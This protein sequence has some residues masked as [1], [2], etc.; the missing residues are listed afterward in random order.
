MSNNF[1]AQQSDSFSV[2]DHS[3]SFISTPDH[4]HDPGAIASGSSS[5]FVSVSREVSRQASPF[6]T[7]SRL[8][9]RTV[10]EPNTIET[11]AGPSRA[12]QEIEQDDFG[13]WADSEVDDAD[14]PSDLKPQLNRAGSHLLHQ[15]L[16]AGDKPQRYASP[17]RSRN[18]S[19]TRQSSRFR[20]RESQTAT[21]D[22]TRTR[23]TYAA[24]FLVISLIT[25]AIQTETAVYIQHTLKWNKAYCM[26]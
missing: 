12:I 1:R 17:S 21:R 11:R 2:P 25:F 19:R 5:S 15:P 20:E 7:Q 9:G 4:D 6:T 13:S 10:G 16:L 18:A 23:Y 14:M 22:D 8:E 26:L 3:H 24:I